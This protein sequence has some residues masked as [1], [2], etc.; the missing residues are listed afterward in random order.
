MFDHNI[1]IKVIFLGSTLFLNINLIN[2]L[3]SK[4]FPLCKCTL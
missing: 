3:Y 2:S 4:Y 1:F